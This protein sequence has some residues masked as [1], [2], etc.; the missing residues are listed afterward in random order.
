MLYSANGIYILKCI[1][2]EWAGVGVVREWPFTAWVYRNCKQRCVMH[3]KRKWQPT[4]AFLPGESQGWGSLVGA[5]YV[6]CTGYDIV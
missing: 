5:D 4:P 3:W 1:H 6:L 2:V